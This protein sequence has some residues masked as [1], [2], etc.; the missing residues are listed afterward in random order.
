[1][2]EILIVLLVSVNLA[3]AQNRTDSNPDSTQMKFPEV[4][5]SATYPGGMGKLYKYFMK[6]MKYP[7][8]AKANLIEGKVFVEFVISEDGSIAD[9]TVRALG[10]N[11]VN[12]SNVT[13]DPACAAEAIRLIQNCPNWI[14]ATIKD[15]PVKQK[16]VLPISFKL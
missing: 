9:E 11:E 7:E 14:P 13:D 1:M 12:S 5:Q 3:Y 6:N 2:Q 10:K 15:K 8:S 4:E 16:L